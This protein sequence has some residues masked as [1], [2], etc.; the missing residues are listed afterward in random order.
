MCG[1]AKL[2]ML[3]G[4]LLGAGGC[5]EEAPPAEDA[6]PGGGGGGGT[7]PIC[8]GCVIG[9]ECLPPG[10]VPPGNGC[11]VCDPARATDAWSDADGL[12]CDDGLFCDG[13]DLCLGGACAAHPEVPCADDGLFCNGVEACD[14][15]LDVCVAGTPACA[16]DG[17]FCDGEESCDEATRSCGHV[18]DPCVG[19]SCVEAE[20]RCCTPDVALGCDPA[21]DVARFDSCG[22]AG[23]VVQVCSHAPDALCA[24][25]VCGCLPGW[26]GANC[27][28][29]VRYV[30]GSAADDAALGTS[31]GRALLTVPAGIAA[32]APS[33]CEVW[34]RTG[35]Y[36]PS[37]S[38]DRFVSFV[39]APGVTLAGGFAGDEISLEA[40]DL[41]ANPTVLSGDLGEAGESWDNTERV[42]LGADGAGLDG[43]VVRGGYMDQGEGA[44]LDGGAGL[45]AYNLSVGMTLRRSLFEDNRT[46]QS[47]GAI[48]ASGAPLLVE[49]CTF[50]NNHANSRGGGIYAVRRGATAG[51]MIVRGS[52]FEGNTTGGWGGGL[53]IWVQSGGYLAE[54][55]G[56]GLLI[57]RSLFT[58]NGA[59]SGAG[60]AIW[61]FEGHGAVFAAHS[62][63]FSGNSANTGSALALSGV[64][65]QLTAELVNTVVWGN[66]GATQ[67]DFDALTVAYSVVEGAGY[68]GTDGNGSLD[69]L[70][71][72]P[73]PAAGPVDLHLGPGSPCIDAGDDTR[74]PL[75]DLDGNGRFDDPLVSRCPTPD[76]PSCSW[77]ADIGAY[78]RQD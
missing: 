3:L 72:Q 59:A 68:D 40:R 65:P 73:D 27:D 34:I 41:E 7:A 39:L 2:G 20:E 10:A 30:D 49:Q 24:D 4:L 23:A 32:A 13:P 51:D 57:E 46:I 55:E 77:S 25:G 38:G 52:R 47:G 45:Y 74:A 53:L 58:G 22:H 78:E 44:D 36:L 35:T 26:S 5:A 33:R 50:R 42:L 6:G 17:L 12:A 69:P 1:P 60:A 43:I 70:F 54:P 37:A 67:L 8:D 71:V 75:L 61:A 63:T 76:A 21:G 11:V 29:C 9:G 31:W 62:S 19:S 56:A 15:V 48:W 28:R 66:P 14:E 64:P 18:G 16:D